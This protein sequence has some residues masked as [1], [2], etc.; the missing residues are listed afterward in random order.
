MGRLPRCGAS[1]TEE[2][3][4]IQVRGVQLM[5]PMRTMVTMTMMILTVPYCQ[6]YPYSPP[7]PHPSSSHNAGPILSVRTS[8]RGAPTAPGG[9]GRWPG[10]VGATAAPDRRAPVPAGAGGRRGGRMRKRRGVM[11]HSRASCCCGCGCCYYYRCSWP[12]HR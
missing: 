1:P 12:L 6:I 7:S 9:T 4:S 2:D 11:M 3:L 5:L 10:S 8:P